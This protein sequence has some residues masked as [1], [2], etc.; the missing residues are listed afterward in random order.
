M[1]K[2]ACSHSLSRWAALDLCPTPETSAPPAPMLARVPLPAGSEPGQEAGPRHRPLALCSAHVL[3]ADRPSAP[4][5]IQGG[6]RG[7]PAGVDGI[8]LQPF[9]WRWW[10]PSRRRRDAQGACHLC[11]CHCSPATL[12]AATPLGLKG[13]AAVRG[14]LLRLPAVMAGAGRLLPTALC[15]GD[16]F[17]V[18]RAPHAIRVARR[19]PARRQ[20]GRE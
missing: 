4:G 17:R 8:R 11:A 9:T 3:F 12:P 10:W 13:R 16:A 2:T 5:S 1:K 14:R 20:A 19:L 18:L 7:A 15:H 6:W